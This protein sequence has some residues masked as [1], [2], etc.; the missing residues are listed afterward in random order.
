[1]AK[2]K[3]PETLPDE[4]KGDRIVPMREPEVRMPKERKPVAV[5]KSEPTEVKVGNMIVR[6]N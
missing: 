1:M 5:A 2:A 3:A 4:G 6:T